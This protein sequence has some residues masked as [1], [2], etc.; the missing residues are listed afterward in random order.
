MGENEKLVKKRQ[1]EDR[2][3]NLFWRKNKSFPPQFGGEEDT[4]E[5]ETM[6]EFWRMINNK[7]VSERW[8]DDESIQEIL[9]GVREKLQRMRYRWGEFM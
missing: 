4:P 9:H 2:M 7:E 8:R 1:R 3:M 5:A 6:L